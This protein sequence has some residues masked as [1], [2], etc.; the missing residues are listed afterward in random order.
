MYMMIMYHTLHV[1]TKSETPKISTNDWTHLRY[2]LGTSHGQPIFNSIYTSSC[3][4]PRVSPSKLIKKLIY[5]LSSFLTSIHCSPRVRCWHATK[6]F[7]K[8]SK[9][10]KIWSRRAFP[11]CWFCIFFNH[12]LA[13][14]GRLRIVMSIATNCLRRRSYNTER[15]F[16]VFLDLGMICLNARF[17]KRSWLWR[18]QERLASISSDRKA[19]FF[20]FLCLQFL[21]VNCF[22]E[23]IFT[24]CMSVSWPFIKLAT[25]KFWNTVLPL[26]WPLL[27]AVRK[28]ASHLILYRGVRWMWSDIVSQS[29]D[30]VVSRQHHKLISLAIPKENSNFWHAPKKLW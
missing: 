7:T 9:R 6:L 8:I 24:R 18:L 13:R 12:A 10:D 20:R 25:T 16:A 29:A 11:V 1:L 2:C 17:S 3:H 15:L 14:C 26:L 22:L 28:V 4:T 23:R 5:G 30:V 19:R 27:K 21:L